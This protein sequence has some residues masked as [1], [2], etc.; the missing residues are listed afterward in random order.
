MLASLK[1]PDNRSQGYNV[2][3][4]SIDQKQIVLTVVW[5]V[6]VLSFVARGLYCLETGENYW[7]I[8]GLTSKAAW[9]E[10]DNTCL[11]K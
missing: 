6:V 11:L 8:F 4:L 3:Y 2:D 9:C 1:L 10:A 5:S 7:A